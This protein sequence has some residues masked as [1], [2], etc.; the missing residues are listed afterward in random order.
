M[1]MRHVHPGRWGGILAAAVALA[2]GAIGLAGATEP[3]RAKGSPP[4]DARAKGAP[5]CHDWAVATARETGRLPEQAWR[6]FT[7]KTL[8]Q[9]CD[10]IPEQLRRAA[11][12]I[13]AV[14]DSNERARILATAAA[15]TLGEECSVAE[16]L[17]EARRVA[18]TCPLP[19]GL[20][21][22]LDEST[23]MD[24]RAVDYAI[25]NVLLRSLKAARQYDAAAER[26]ILNFTLSA[27][28]VGEDTRNREA[29]RN[30]RGR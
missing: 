15:A 13:G 19:P 22:R 29:R 2:A 27:Q 21:F 30:R 5:T 3:P 16:P 20:S 26:V 11:L 28:I 8:G 6:D 18:S 14:K 9:S 25:L 4:G 1:T 24:I 23:L 10:A 7:I 12:Q 17:A